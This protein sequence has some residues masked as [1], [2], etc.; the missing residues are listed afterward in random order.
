MTPCENTLPHNASYGAAWNRKQI[1]GQRFGKLL[2]VSSAGSRNGTSLWLCKCDCGETREVTHNALRNGTWN[3]GCSRHKGFPENGSS[4]RTYKARGP[5][6]LKPQTTTS[7]RNRVKHF[8]LHGAKSRNLVWGLPDDMFDALVGGNCVYCGSEPNARMKVNKTAQIL[9]NGIDRV[10][11]SKGYT[12]D[13]VVSCCAMCNRAKSAMDKETF[14]AW[15]KRVA[16]HYNNPEI[17][18]A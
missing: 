1:E 12:P 3:C 10:D 14:V 13:N 2:V 11:N 7:A 9:F 15:L 4:H 5:Y 18:M 16:K 6:Q 8:Y 17:S